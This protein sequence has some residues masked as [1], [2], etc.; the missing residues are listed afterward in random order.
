MVFGDHGLARG[1]PF[2]MREQMEKKKGKA[3]I[4]EAPRKMS[5]R[6]YDLPDIGEDDGLLKVDMVGVCG[7]DPGIYNGTKGRAARPYPII[8]GHEII[9]T[10]ERIGKNASKAHG[11]QEGDRAIVEMS[12]GCGQCYECI[13]GKYHLC[14]KF[15]SYGTMISC[16]D[17]PHFWGGYAEYLYIAP[18]AKVHKVNPLLPLEAGVLVSAILGNG[19][20]WIKI[21]GISI[22]DTVLI[23]GPGQ[24][25]LACVIAANEAGASSIIITGRSHHQLRFALAREYG[26]H[27]CIDVEKEDLAEAVNEI[28]KGKMADFVIDTTGNPEGATHAINLVKRN[29]VIILPGMYGATTE[30]PLILDKIVVKEIKM[31]G[32][33]SHEITSV[34]PAISLAESRK[35]AVEKMVTHRFRLDEAEIAVQTA[36]REIKEENFIKAVIIP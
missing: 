1:A 11:V 34:I 17:P 32:V 36:G 14:G 13:T 25:G 6:E 2:R 20:R 22:G 26:A 33:F 29:G 28:T 35:Y 21:G 4:L 5:M 31:F 18:R 10:V 7:G 19:I 16:K 9:G 30:I 3:V 8:M 12:I 24:Q 27:H 15:L 23:E